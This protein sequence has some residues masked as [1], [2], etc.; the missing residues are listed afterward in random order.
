MEESSKRKAKSEKVNSA[1]SQKAAKSMAE[2]M[3][4]QTG[5]FPSLR[6][7][8]FI[9]GTVK[10]L[11]PQEILLDIGAKSDALVIEYD[12]KNLQNLLSFLK[13]GDKVTASVISTESEE[14]F[15]VVSLRRMLEGMVYS[16]L[17]K[18]V[19]KGEVLSVMIS[20]GSTRGGYFVETDE[21]VRGFL[22]NSQVLPGERLEGKRISVKIIESDREKKRVIFS[23][24][25]TVYMTSPEELG[26]AVKKDTIVDAKIVE[27][28]PHG[29]YV[30][31]DKNGTP[32]EGF[33][34]IS[35]ISYD[36]V[37]DIHSRFKAGE[38]VMA[39]VLEIDSDNRRVN[40]SLKRLEKDT[41]ESTKSS[42]PLE[43][44]VTAKVIDSK[45]RGVSVELEAKVKGFI[46][47]EKVPTGTTYSAN[48]TVEAEVTGYDE[49]RRL[50]L[51][52]PV[53]TTKFVGYR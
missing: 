8:Q 19:K 11:T 23:Q 44:K 43:K 29:L 6:K 51:L 41:F 36:R 21:G 32:I 47:A 1:S 28:S 34:H 50:I 3:S 25:A 2:L 38:V 53:L 24:K 10:K 7:G 46:P 22:P 48:D 26:K 16:S 17:E 18:Q 15:P 52:S 35:E 9:E 37:E 33:I 14:G 31:L 13:V 45:N 42:Y 4:S 12:K 20:D 5:K 30:T 49:K 39:Q 40:L 27:V